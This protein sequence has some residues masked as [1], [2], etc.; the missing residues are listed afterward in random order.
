MSQKCPELQTIRLRT[1]CS[2]D[3]IFLKTTDFDIG[4]TYFAETSNT[5]S[6]FICGK[7][8]ASISYLGLQIDF[9]KCAYSLFE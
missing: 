4:I 1:H 2:S 9:S 3:G 7:Y 8:D 5:L 6:I